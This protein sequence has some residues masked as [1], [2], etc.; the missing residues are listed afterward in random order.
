MKFDVEIVETIPC[1]RCAGEAYLT[2]RYPHP[3]YLYPER[4]PTS[5]MITISL[6]AKC[7]AGVGS[8]HGILAYFAFHSTVQTVNAEELAVLIAEWLSAL[9]KGTTPEKFQEDLD[10]YHRGE[11]D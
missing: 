11:F 4:Q 10:A 6:C 2:V 5:G 1:H 7:D 3:G 8:A 9:P